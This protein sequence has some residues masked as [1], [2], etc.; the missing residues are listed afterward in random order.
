MYYKV[1][2]FSRA[3]EE[4]DKLTYLDVFSI[5]QVTTSQKVDFVQRDCTG[6][7][8]ER[9]NVFSPLKRQRL[10]KQNQLYGTN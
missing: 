10:D 1:P 8:D 7:L 3:Q 5:I 4:V 2:L 6:N 9:R